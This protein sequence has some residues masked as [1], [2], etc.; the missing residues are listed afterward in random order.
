[1]KQCAKCHLWKD[2]SE[3]YAAKGTKDNLRTDCKE[4]KKK[5]HKQRYVKQPEKVKAA[6]RKYYHENSKKMQATVARYRQNNPLKIEAQAIVRKAV[7]VGDLPPVTNLPCVTCGKEAVDYHHPD[8]SFPLQVM[9]LCRTC[10][11]RVHTKQNQ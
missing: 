3:F 8:Y 4:C 7:G 6:A 1:M 9:A 10:H 5:A 11:R 2:E